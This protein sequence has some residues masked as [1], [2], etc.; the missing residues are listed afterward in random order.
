MLPM[1]EVVAMELLAQHRV[2]ATLTQA[3][4][5][6]ARAEVLHEY[7]ALGG[8]PHDAGYQSVCQT[9]PA[10]MKRPYPSQYISVME[11]L[12]SQGFPE[13]KAAEIASIFG[14]DLKRAYRA[15][16]GRDPRTFMAVFE[17]ATSNVC[18]YDRAQD[19]ELLGS[20]WR[21]FQ[22]GRS[23]F[24]ENY[25]A[26]EQRRVDEHHLRQMSQGI[27][28]RPAPGWGAARTRALTDRPAPF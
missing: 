14:P 4:A 25:A 5:L 20:C 26:S 7:R 27:D 12:Q 3:Q 13:R 21:M 15:E 28:D 22:R 19:A 2:E 8:N 1:S 17:G 24:K 10:E 23:W 6:K 11:Y 18:I 16:Y 9:L